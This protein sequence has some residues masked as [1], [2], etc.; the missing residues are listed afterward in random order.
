[1]K[2]SVVLCPVDFSPPSQAAFVEACG[3][4]R[5]AGARLVL[6]H[7]SELD[8]VA[9]ELP[10]W[11]A[12]VLQKDRAARLGK[13]NELTAQARASGVA[14]VD[15]DIV[16]GPAWDRIVATARTAGADLVVMGTHGR[17]G[18][19]HALL[20]SVAEKVI[21]HAPCSVLVVRTS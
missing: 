5:E 2:P 18:L 3:I 19:R 12:D 9:P 14:A 1:M 13:L 10:I 21:R 6:I 20:G 8:I 17:T 16:D 15:A 11:P 7:V 4:A